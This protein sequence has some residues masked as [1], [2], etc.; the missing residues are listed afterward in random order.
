MEIFYFLAL[1]ALLGYLWNLSKKKN[2]STAGKKQVTIDKDM[3]PYGRCEFEISGESYKTNNLRKLFKKYEVSPGGYHVL[4]AVLETDP[5][6]PY[7]KNA[8]EVFIDNLSVGYIPKG[9]AKKVSNLLEGNT[10]NGK[11]RV[12]ALIKY[13][14]DDINFSNVKL[15]M[16]WPPSFL[17]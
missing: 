13:A 7:D 11:A 5:L 15:D 10:K 6:N 2:S 9:K 12:R 4:D 1:L 3:K 16:D 17:R 14:K 8:V